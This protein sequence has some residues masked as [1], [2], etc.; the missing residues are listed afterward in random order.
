MS[1]L[2]AIK[3]FIL[4]L[5]LYTAC[6]DYKER[7]IPDFFVFLIFVLSSL[8]FFL[9]KGDIRDFFFYIFL[10]SIPILILSFIVDNISSIKSKLFDFILIFVSILVGL[11]VPFDYKLKYITACM[12]LIS[13]M[14]F[15]SVFEKE[16]ED[17]S[18][19]AAESVGGG[20]IKLIAALG[21]VLQNQIILFLFISFLLAFIYMKIK[22]E[23]NIYLAPFMF[24][25][26]IPF[27]IFLG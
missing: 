6:K 9:Q 14:L 22:R 5:L 13:G 10:A 18:S 24:L 17:Y 1:I 4:I 2:T 21:P 15:M 20:D 19:E 12:F 16:K 3:I 11:T 26:F 25:G 7:I 27:I 23:K 8:Y